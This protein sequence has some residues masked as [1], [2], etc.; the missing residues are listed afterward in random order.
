MDEQYRPGLLSGALLCLLLTCGTVSYA[1]VATLAD[2]DRAEQV[3]WSDPQAA[4]QRLDKLQPQAQSSADLVQL[5]TVRG[6]AYADIRQDEDV[7]AL[8]ARLHA[9]GRDDPSAEATSHLVQA[10]LFY[11]RD[12]YDRAQAELKL[13]GAEATLSELERDRKSTRLN[14]SHV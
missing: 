12:Q 3:G 14:S 11:Q 5:L 2:I 7:Q 1:Q 6:L 4:L 10:Y 9:M 8:I 13:I